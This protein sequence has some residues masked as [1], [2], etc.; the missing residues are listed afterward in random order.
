MKTLQHNKIAIALFASALTLGLSS[1][2]SADVPQDKSAVASTPISTTQ[3]VT[4]YIIP[5]ADGNQRGGNRSCAD[6]GKAY[7]GNPLHYQC[8]TDKKDYE[9]FTSQATLEDP[10]IFEPTGG[11]PA[12]CANAISVVV[13]D[14]TIVD[15]T[16]T[17]PIGAAI[18]KG[19]PAANTYV[20]MPQKLKDTGLASPPVSGGF[21]EL[22]NIGGFCWNPELGPPLG[23]CYEDETAWAAGDRY[24]QR[25]NWATYVE[26]K[27]E[28]KTVD[29]FA[30]QDIPVGTVTFSVP[31]GDNPDGDNN[32]T[33]T[34]NLSGDWVFGINY[35][36]D[37]EGNLKL[38]ED[39]NPIRDDNIK[40]QD[41]AE[42]PSG[43]PSPG[44]FMW[45]KVGDGQIG[46]IVV[47]QNNYYG[48]H[49][50]VALPVEC[51]TD[52]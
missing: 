39:G 26:Y 35:E 2:A 25:G 19:G 41:Y 22:S 51:P 24:T 14:G 43:N 32:V 3:V 16:S 10:E 42:A 17:Y 18:I 30:G 34:I 50:D 28:V 45:K 6:V 48:V 1:G 33:I 21:A 40:V 49:V 37:E 47:K 52:E 4:P 7:F 23:I 15:W 12:E 13:T 29:L 20:Y 9:N 46:E 5:P 44:L 27:S 38:D 11:L 8:R 36:L 31:D